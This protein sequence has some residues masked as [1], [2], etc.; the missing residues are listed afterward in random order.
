MTDRE[1]WETLTAPETESV[2]EPE[3]NKP[4]AEIAKQSRGAAANLASLVRIEH[5][6]FSLPFVIM[7]TLIGSGGVP[8]IKTIALIIIAL[9][10]ARTAAMSFNRVADLKYDS[11]NPRTSLRELVTGAV[12]KTAAGW[13]VA[14]SS[15][16]FVVSAFALNSICG[17][18]SFPVLAL[19]LGYSYTKR[20][21]WLSHA[22][23]GLALG[24]SPGAAWLAVGAPLSVVPFIMT[25]IVLFWVA[26]FDILY[27]LADVEFD[28]REG[29]ESIPAKFGIRK[30]LFVSR[31]SHFLCALLMV[32]LYGEFG[33]PLWSYLALTPA[34]ALLIRQH[35]LVSENDLSKLS[36]A[37]FTANGWLGV[38]FAALTLVVYFVVN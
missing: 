29:L 22:I 5:T 23:L 34:L 1:T 32:A 9:T 19:I 26:G 13:L 37:F 31:A 7:A 35:T 8:G 30:A 6:V 27:S 10:S 3:S 28:R 15:L 33:F 16:F 2:L 38:I 36:V 25:A 14:L 18:L 20:F 17:V 12:S 21:T 4:E 11:R 24:I